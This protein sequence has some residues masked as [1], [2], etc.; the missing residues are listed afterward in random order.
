MNA[1]RTLGLSG[2]LTL[3]VGLLLAVGASRAAADETTPADDWSRP[4]SW[5]VRD[6][7]EIRE[8]VMQHLE[9]ASADE[10]SRRRAAELWPEGETDVA[11]ERML[12]RLAE[13]LALVDPRVGELV[14]WRDEPIE[15][16]RPP[17]AEW[18]LAEDA[19]VDPLVQNNLRLFVGRALAQ[20]RLFDASL[21]YLDGL[22]PEDVV[23]PASLLFFQAVG[24]HRLVELDKSGDAVGT[25][26]EREEEIPLRYRTIAR[27]M[28]IDIEGV[29]VDSLDHIAR[30]M[31]D[32]YRRLDLA[33][34]D[35]TVQMVEEGV[36]QSLQK[37]IE[38]LER[39]QQ[40]QQSGAGGGPQPNA[41]M[42]ETQFATQNSARQV[43][44]KDIGDRSGWGDLPDKD[45]EEA[46]QQIGREFPA[47]YRDV[48]EQYFKT[49]AAGED[50]SD[51]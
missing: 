23:D 43:E 21:Q 47:H 45:R 20:R 1:K 22:A 42:Q 28:E 11:A 30:R 31:D 29:E 37:M 26:V 36:V 4:A 8:R 13:S 14:T 46:M 9:K 33:Q 19:D 48:I 12:D 49:L 32:V 2:G 6:V 17:Q 3:A 34:A 35:K 41:P 24:H 7:A 16:I 27:L 40:Q 5:S 10:A 50:G 39:Q 15:L 25:L 18:L 38:E 51:D 44:D